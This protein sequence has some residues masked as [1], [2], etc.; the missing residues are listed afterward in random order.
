MTFV[1]TFCLAV[2]FAAIFVFGEKLFAGSRVHKRRALSVA[3]GVAV[4]YVFV[5]LLP[6]LARAG[7]TFVEI[8]ADQPLPWPEHRVYAAALVGFVLF[9]GLEHLVHWFRHSGHREKAGSGVRDP[10]LILHIGGFALYVGLI[11]YLMVRGIDE[12]EVPVLLYGT[13]MGLHF[14]STGHSLHH[15]HGRGYDIRGRWA[16]ALA[17]LGG[18]VCGVL[19]ELPKPVA[20]TLLGLVSGGVVMNS[21]IA[22]LPGEK[23]GRFVPFCLGAA[24]YAVLLFFV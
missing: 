11:S 6:E 18:W 15:E 2:L 9:Y 14:L 3:G 12:R 13:A 20:I 22:E 10:I 17:A 7:E 21:M 1:E 16:L 5:H 8:T 23:D 19:V 24:A 4:A